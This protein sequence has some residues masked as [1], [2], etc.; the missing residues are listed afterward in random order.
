M[1]GMLLAAL[2]QTI[3]STALPT[4]VGDLGGLSQ[5]SW[6]VTAYLLTSTV[7]SPIYGKIGDLYGR[8]G[9][10]QFA[11]AVFLVGSALSGLSQSIVQLIAFRA[12]QGLGAGGLLVGSLAIIGDVVPA[13]QRGRYQGYFGAVFGAASV[14][15]P[16]LGGFLVDHLSWRWVFFVNLPLGIL[17]LAATSLFLHLP[18]SRIHHQ[19]DY[20]GAALLG[21]GVT[22]IILLTTWGGSQYA[23]G[24]PEIIGLGVAG[25]LLLIA[26]V[27][28]EWHAAEPIIPLSLFRNSIFSVASAIGLIVGFGLFGAVVFLPQYMQIVKGIDPTTSGL[29]ML[30]MMAGLLVA[31]IGSGQLITRYGRYK[32]F[33]MVGTALIAVALYL[34]STLAP[35]TSQILVSVYIGILGVGLGLVIQVIVLVVQN[36]VDYRDLGTATSDSTFF[37]SMGGSFGVSVL[38]TVFNNTFGQD[39]ARALPHGVSA[40]RLTSGSGTTSPAQLAQLPQPIHTAYIHAYAQSLDTV[41]LFALPFAVAAFVLTWFLQELP[42]RNQVESAGTAEANH[43]ALAKNRAAHV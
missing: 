30:P 41:F 21:S 15:G 5:L 14:V 26:F 8:K 32:I 37:R 2:D 11:I 3:V 10:F 42:L 18:K 4:I 33:P 40:A 20:L 25:A 24:S 16:L 27:L 1:L 22:A 35:A 9:I 29:L 34:L 13:R 12:L 43:Q 38:G 23:W 6:V 19:I 31:S 39:L 7:S 17:A 28:V 36:A